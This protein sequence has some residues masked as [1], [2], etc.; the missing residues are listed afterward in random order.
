MRQGLPK[1]AGESLAARAL[2]TMLSRTRGHWGSSVGMGKGR[3]QAEME[4]M[5]RKVRAVG[6]CRLA[7]LKLHWGRG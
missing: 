7:L 1:D 5:A 2:S 6:S 4:A 3:Y